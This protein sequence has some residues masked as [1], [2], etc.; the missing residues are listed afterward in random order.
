MIKNC[1]NCGN[2]GALC[3]SYCGDYE[4]WKPIK[5]ENTKVRKDGLT[6]QEGKVMDSL[7]DA[8]NE[9]V[10]LEKQH[11]TDIDEFCDGIHRCQH[12]L[13]IRILRRDYSEGYP[14]K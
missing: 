14:I 10:K 11:P 7:V 12:A 3:C 8:W 1:S 6:E 13:T 5:E 4:G 2:K 9:Y